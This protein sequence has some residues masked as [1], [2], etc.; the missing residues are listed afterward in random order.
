MQK[1]LNRV[2]F[3]STKCIYEDSQ[4]TYCNKYDYDAYLLSD[5][6]TEILIGKGIAFLYLYGKAIDDGF[7]IID[8]FD[9][10]HHES[11]YD[12]LFDGNVVDGT[13]GMKDEWEEL[14]CDSFNLNI[15]VSDRLEILPEYRHKGYGKIIREIKRAFFSGCYGI[16]VLHSFPL[17]LESFNNSEDEWRAKQQYGS[18]EQD[19]KK[20]FASL[21]R[22]YKKDG[23]K[24]YKRTEF[25][26]RLP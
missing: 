7:D 24:K 25:F 26:Y 21:N 3:K 1:P 14:M 4:S 16:E 19:S 13:I 9:E 23:Y 6:G 10:N 2:D 22:C 18:M 20:A 15:L 17:Q 12:L 11:I 8:A 5:D